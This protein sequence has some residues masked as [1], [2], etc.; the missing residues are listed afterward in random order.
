MCLFQGFGNVGS[1][2]AI[3]LCRAGAKLI[4][5]IE[6]DGGIFDPNGIDP[7]A[8]VE[9]RQVKTS[10]HI[11]VHDRRRSQDRRRHSTA[12]SHSIALIRWL[13]FPYNRTI[14]EIEHFLFLRSQSQTIAM[15]RR[16]AEKCFHIIG[17]DRRRSPAIVCDYMETSLKRSNFK[18][19]GYMAGNKEMPYEL[20]CL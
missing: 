18:G 16:I 20:P 9:Y 6:H 12:G 13:V 15:N 3:N 4:G 8:L 2:S 5:V 14:A 1:H 10:F 11:I 17:Q 7:N 19:Q